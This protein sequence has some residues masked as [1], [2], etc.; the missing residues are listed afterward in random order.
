MKQRW[1]AG[2]L[3][4][5]MVSLSLSAGIPALA[6]DRRSGHSASKEKL[7]KIGTLVGAAA[8]GYALSKGKGTWALIGAGATLLSYSQWKKQIG[9]RHKDER[10]RRAAYSRYRSRWAAN[11][12]GRR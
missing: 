1:I 3:A 10:A 7:G 6:K 9:R 2:S 4:T 11:N 8:T 5:V 12:R